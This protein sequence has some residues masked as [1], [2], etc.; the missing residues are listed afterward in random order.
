MRRAANT[1]GFTTPYFSRKI[2]FPEKFYPSPPKV[3]P[4]GRGF[5]STSA[6]PSSDSVD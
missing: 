4:L 6:N 5:P 2:T 3:S 1:D